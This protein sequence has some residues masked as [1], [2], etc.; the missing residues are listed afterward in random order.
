MVLQVSSRICTRM[1]YTESTFLHARVC[2]SGVVSDRFL[3]DCYCRG[4]MYYYHRRYIGIGLSAGG[5][6]NNKLPG[7]PRLRNVGH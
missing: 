6:L 4:F 7:M 1:E 5:A 2:S 3:S